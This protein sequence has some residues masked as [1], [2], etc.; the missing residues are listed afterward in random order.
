VLKGK[1][2][3]MLHAGSVGGERY[4]GDGD[5]KEPACAG[6]VVAGYS[7]TSRRAPPVE[8]LCHLPR[9]VTGATVT[10]DLRRTARS[11]RQR[12]R[13]VCRSGL[14][15]CRSQSIL[16]EVLFFKKK[17]FKDLVRLSN[18]SRSE[19]LPPADAISRLAFGYLKNIIVVFL[20]LIAHRA[21]FISLCLHFGREGAVHV[22]LRSAAED[23][24]VT[25]DARKDFLKKKG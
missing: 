16:L 9:H 7:S 15:S 13:P 8:R 11:T 12:L 4:F 6:C 21:P 1:I 20:L 14:P 18:R 25:S 19:S 23:E 24:F 10:T 2:R 22:L 17:I 5:V 3:R